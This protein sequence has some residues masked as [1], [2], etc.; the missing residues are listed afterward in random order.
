MR[1]CFALLVVGALV[2]AACSDETTTSHPIGVSEA[3]SGM[4]PAESDAGGVIDSGVDAGPQPLAELPLRVDCLTGDIAFVVKVKIG[5]T[6]VDAL[7]DTGSSGLRIVDGVVT[8]TDLAS[9]SNTAVQAAYGSGTVVEGVVATANVSLGALTTAAPIKLEIVTSAHCSAAKPGCPVANTSFD[10]FAFKGAAGGTYKAIIGVGMR[11]G[12]NSQQVANPIAQLPM[13]PAYVIDIGAY[14]ATTGV[15]RIGPTPVQVAGFKTI[16]HPALPNGVALDNGVGAFD[17]RQMP[18]C[19]VNTTQSKT[20]CLDALFDCGNGTTDINASAAAGNGNIPVGNV[21][22]VSLLTTL[23]PTSAPLGTYA[24]TVA[25]PPKA[26]LDKF[27]IAQDASDI[28]NIGTSVFF[29]FQVYLDQAN[30]IEGVDPF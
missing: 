22:D 24:V 3:G 5:T 21:V 26:G 25:A 1:S 4:I 16:T 29:R 17:D 19:I 13:K 7:V 14:G 23:D 11:N 12:P 30:G 9:R 6:E 28:I 8:A 27:V 15:L 20:F 2:A 10:Q 18:V